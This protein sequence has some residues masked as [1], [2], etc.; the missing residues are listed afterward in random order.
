MNL[1][2]QKSNPTG[3][4][5]V[6]ERA[7]ERPD[8]GPKRSLKRFST[9]PQV[10]VQNERFNSP[11]YVI[12]EKNINRHLGD[13]MVRLLGLAFLASPPLARSQDRLV[14]IPG[15]LFFWSIFLEY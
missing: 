10:R 11:I 5:K 14:P 4:G 7:K 15:K 8:K 6:R 9:A 12:R 13:R 2:V 3:P 1:S